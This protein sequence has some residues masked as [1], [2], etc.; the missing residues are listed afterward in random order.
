[1]GVCVCVARQ[2]QEM[3]DRRRQE[4]ANRAAVGNLPVKAP[5][6]HVRPLGAQQPRYFSVVQLCG[7]VGVG[8]TW[9]LPADPPPLLLGPDH[10]GV[11]RTWYPQTGQLVY[12]H[13]LQFLDRVIPNTLFLLFAP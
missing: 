8:I 6:A 10:E 13:I 7:F 12:L 3:A 2:A 4:A 5:P 1:M 11:Q 9:P